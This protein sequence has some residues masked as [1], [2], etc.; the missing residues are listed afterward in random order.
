MSLKSVWYSLISKSYYRLHL[1]KEGNVI[2]VLETPITEKSY[3][4][5]SSRKT[6]YILAD[7]NTFIKNNN[8]FMCFSDIDNAIAFSIMS[9]EL[10]EDLKEEQIKELEKSSRLQNFYK[11]LSGDSMIKFVN[12]LSIFRLTYVPANLMGIW[13][14][15][16][17]LNMLMEAPKNKNEIPNMLLWIGLGAAVLVVIYMIW[18]R[19]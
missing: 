10:P 12:K 11:A 3:I 18:G 7:N 19:G 14:S 4:Y 8:C 2:S 6:A 13:L 15:G 9:S 5:D 17:T 16:D 1:T